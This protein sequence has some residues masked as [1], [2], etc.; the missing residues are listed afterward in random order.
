MNEYTYQA[1]DEAGLTRTGTVRAHNLAQARERVRRLNRHVLSVRPARGR[2]FSTDRFGL[3]PCALVFR[4]L[5]T[6]LRAGHPAAD[7]LDLLLRGPEGADR[8]ARTLLHRMRDGLE[9]GDRLSAVL[10]GLPGFSPLFAAMIDCGERSGTLREVSG[11][12]A[13]HCDRQLR[14]RRRVASL[15]VYP[16]LVLLLAAGVAAFQGIYVLPAYLDVY[17]QSGIP[18]PSLLRGWTA[19]GAPQVYIPVCLLL[20]ACAW[21]CARGIRAMR[22]RPERLMRIPALGPLLGT[23]FK[24]NVFGSLSLLSLAGLPFVESVRILRDSP[25]GRASRGVLGEL[26]QKLRAGQNVWKAFEN[27]PGLDGF[28]SGHLQMA[29]QSGSL[30]EALKFIANRNEELFNDSVESLVALLEPLVTVAVGLVVA[31]VALTFLVP[32]YYYTDA[33]H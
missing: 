28:E 6:L 23:A 31:A 22:R 1:L 8:R 33:V 32:I 17:R 25:A 3:K 13:E 2:L 7:A 15:C 10:S 27:F 16:A 29:Q 5:H 18:V 21:G 26:E 24:R 14:W 19:L 4:P 11:L 12:L 30:P 20:L 9:S